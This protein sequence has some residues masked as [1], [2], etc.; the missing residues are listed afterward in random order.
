M[1]GLGFKLSELKLLKVFM[2]CLSVYTYIMLKSY[3]LVDNSVSE[4]LYH[5]QVDKYQTCGLLFYLEF[6]HCWQIRRTETIS[7]CLNIIIFY[8]CHRRQTP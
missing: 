3:L 8:S 6:Q 2:V 4:L 7:Y 1:E 5:E